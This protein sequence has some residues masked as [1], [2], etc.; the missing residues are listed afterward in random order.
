MT[1]YG[2]IKSAYKYTNW[3]F[4]GQ[5]NVVD[6][7]IVINSMQ[8]YKKG[9]WVLLD[10]YTRSCFIYGMTI[11]EFL[12]INKHRKYPIG[13]DYCW[14][15]A[16]TTY[17]QNCNGAGKFDWISRITGPQPFD[18]IRYKYVR[19]E[20][21]FLT[22]QRNDLLKSYIFAPTK[23]FRGERMCEKCMG[24]GIHIHKDSLKNLLSYDIDKIYKEG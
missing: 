24:T 9:L 1:D 14:H 10:N 13:N 11:K 3:R 4:I 12:E 17:C 22:F 21:K 15:S 2:W 16:R 6:H 5:S 8:R 20:S 18:K 23:I 19:D 7:S